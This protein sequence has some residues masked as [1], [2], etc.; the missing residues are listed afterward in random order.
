MM[1]E[2]W[3][4]KRMKFTTTELDQILP[5]LHLQEV[6]WSYGYR[7]SPQKALCIFLARLSWPL[8][9]H[10]MM[11]WFGCSRSQL[12]TIFND[13]A[14]F[15]Y[16]RFR[17]KLFFDRRRLKQW[18]RIFARKFLSKVQLLTQEAN[19]VLSQL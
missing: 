3:I 9:L 4:K 18:L 10:D 14:I 5:L 16:Q 2:E 15:L 12:S 19:P 1:S 8:R 11:D 6:Q 17:N 7:P 13:V